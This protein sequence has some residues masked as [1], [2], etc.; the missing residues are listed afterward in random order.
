MGIF[1]T[2]QARTFRHQGTIP[3]EDEDKY[4][5]ETIEQASER[6]T[7]RFARICGVSFVPVEEIILLDGT[8]TPTVLLPR[9]MVTEII[10]LESL[11]GTTWSAVDG[12]YRLIPDNL[13]LAAGCGRWTCGRANLRITIVH[14]YAEP[15]PDIVR[16]ALILAVDELVGSNVSDR[17]TQ[18]TN[19]FGTYN[20]AVPGWR[21]GQWTGLPAVDSVLQ[22][23]EQASMWV[24]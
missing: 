15:P 17:A 11:S 20:L 21:A 3:L 22:Q 8:G 9:A 4:G 7:A 10:G 5:N 6:I 24:G 19:N 23:Y 1:T 2:E 16:A 13:L 12:D 18:Q 14:G